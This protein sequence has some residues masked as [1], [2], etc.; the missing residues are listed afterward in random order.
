MGAYL[1]S[2]PPTMAEKG[3]EALKIAFL[4]SFDQAQAD[5]TSDD[6]PNNANSQAPPHA[7]PAQGPGPVLP[8]PSGM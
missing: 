8:P 7:S 2:V 6:R 4:P 3:E 1:P 5:F